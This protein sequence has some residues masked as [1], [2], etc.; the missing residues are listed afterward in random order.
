[1]AVKAWSRLV[2]AGAVLLLASAVPATA[3]SAGTH[4]HRRHVEVRRP[5]AVA[6]V[7]LGEYDGMEVALEFVEPDFAVLVVEKF[8]AKAQV[9]TATKY[10]TRFRG[11]LPLGR[12]RARFG[13]IGTVSLRFRPDGKERHGILTKNCSGRPPREEGGSFVGRVSLRGEDDYFHVSARR[14]RGV[15]G[16]TF[17]LRC[18]VNHQALAYP[19]PSLR[20]LVEP[21][22]T[23]FGFEASLVAL[24]AGSHTQGREVGL[25]ASHVD[26]SSAGAELQAAEF[27][28]QGKMP[29]G[30]TAWMGQ[31]PAGTLRSTLSGEHPATAT[32]EPAAPFSGAAEY[33]GSSPTSHSWT[34]TLA[35]Q[36]P[37]L[38]QP[39]AGP[40]FYS[41]LCVISPL[42]DPGGCDFV[43]PDMQFA[44]PAARV[45]RPGLPGLPG[46]AALPWRPGW[47][48]PGWQIR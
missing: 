38:A 26:G 41:D 23:A 39:L 9:A 35:V 16:R 6:F 33:V 27:E 46:R 19:P 21:Q 8:D 7:E 43:P 47:E 42:R 30:R 17:R 25:R 48:I 31:S 45:E 3:A 34:G 32:L 14:A 15:L 2:T 37:G 18:R 22:I 36:F 29:V 44:E 24:T 4:A 40:D 5:T 11:S 12:L 20:E 13:S 10:G 28:Y 1:M